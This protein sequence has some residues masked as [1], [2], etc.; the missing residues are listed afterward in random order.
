MREALASF[1]IQGISSATVRW[2]NKRNNNIK[3]LLWVVGFGI[4]AL[5]LARNF[6]ARGIWGQMSQ[7]IK[8]MRNQ[9]VK[10]FS[11]VINKKEPLQNSEQPSFVD[12]EA[13]HDDE[14]RIQ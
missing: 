4:V 10:S 6:N 14:L 3:T 11:N 5:A 1:L 2:T 7:P 13:V 9:M 12:G 8:N